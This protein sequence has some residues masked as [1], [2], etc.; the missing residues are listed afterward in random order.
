MILLLMYKWG[1][2]N[3]TATYS[4][5]VCIVKAAANL[6]AYDRGYTNTFSHTKIVLWDKT[7]DEKI[8]SGAQDNNVRVGSKAYTQTIE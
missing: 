7:I 3:P 6:V 5:Q 4:T 8:L 2:D 1:Y